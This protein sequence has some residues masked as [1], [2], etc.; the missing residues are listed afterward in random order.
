MSAKSVLV[1]K[2][3]RLVGEIVETREHKYAFSYSDEWLQS[4]FNIS[5]LSFCRWKRKCLS[6]QKCILRDCSVSLRIACRIHGEDFWL[7]AC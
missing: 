3:E 7:T 1:C 2:D 5:P 6:L 4:G